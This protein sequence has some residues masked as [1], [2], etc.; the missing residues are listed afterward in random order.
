MLAQITTNINL[1]KIRQDQITSSD[2]IIQQKV[3]YKTKR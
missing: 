3:Y 2:Q 1:T